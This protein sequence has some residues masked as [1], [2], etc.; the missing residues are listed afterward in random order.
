M[1]LGGDLNAGMHSAGLRSLVGRGWVEDDSEVGID[2]LL[3]RRAE[4]E[5][6]ATRWLPQRRDLRL[7]GSLPLRLSDH[8]PVDAV[9]ALA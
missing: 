4:L 6:P 5:W 3:V 1:I 7:N 8:D 9:V 2:H